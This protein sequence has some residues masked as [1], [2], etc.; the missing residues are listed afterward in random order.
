MA[1]CFWFKLEMKEGNSI[2]P[3]CCCCMSFLLFFLLGALL[4]FIPFNVDV[5]YTSASHVPRR[6]EHSGAK[7]NVANR[8]VPAY[9]LNN[10]EGIPKG[11]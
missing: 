3:F 4:L 5:Y 10:V 1:F 2:L 11:A 6:S 9:K 8:N 7:W